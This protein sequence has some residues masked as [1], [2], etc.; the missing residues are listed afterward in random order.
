MHTYAVDRYKVYKMQ[1]DIDCLD[2]ILC[3]LLNN[4]F[5]FS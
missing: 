5:V 1:T 3:L 2:V 4:A